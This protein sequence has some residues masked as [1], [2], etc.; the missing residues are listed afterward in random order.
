MPS[1]RKL[2]KWSAKKKERGEVNESGFPATYRPKKLHSTECDS[3]M[4]WSTHEMEWL[5]R[6][7]WSPLRTVYWAR[8][9]N[10][11][12]F[13]VISGG[14]GIPLKHALIFSQFLESDPKGLV[15]KYLA[16]WILFGA[17]IKISKIDKK[18]FSSYFDACHESSSYLAFRSY[19]ALEKKIVHEELFLG[20]TSTGWHTFFSE[21]NS[22]S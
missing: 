20:S 16:D 1:E 4:R 6:C 19:E 11:N 17:V 7:E 14:G 13:E 12:F 2:I 15:L 3:V 21:K 18:R 10:P 5:R 22:L 9:I 8:K